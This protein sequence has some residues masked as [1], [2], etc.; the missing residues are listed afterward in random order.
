MIEFGEKELSGSDY[1]W[2]CFFDSLFFFLYV[3]LYS[4][5]FIFVVEV[6]FYK[7][8]GFVLGGFIKEF[9]NNVNY[10]ILG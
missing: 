9:G 6:F 7:R 10:L 4:R 3:V 5:G 8:V 1:C 2:S